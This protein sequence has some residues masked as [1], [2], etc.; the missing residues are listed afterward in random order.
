MVREV[1]TEMHDTGYS[2]DGADTDESG[3]GYSHDC[4][5]PIGYGAC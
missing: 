1:S 2:H 5:E 4:M 3:G